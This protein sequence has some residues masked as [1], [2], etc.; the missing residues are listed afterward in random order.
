MSERAGDD[1]AADQWVEK[2]GEVVLVPKFEDRARLELPPAQY[3]DDDD[4]VEV[5]P[6]LPVEHGGRE[7]L[8]RSA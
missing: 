2:G 7:R 1:E 4:D 5:G 3:D 6:H 8:D